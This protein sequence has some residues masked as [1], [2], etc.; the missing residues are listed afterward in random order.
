[1][2]HQIGSG[3]TRL[4]SDQ[5]MLG[6]LVVGTSLLFLGGYSAREASRVGG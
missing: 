1:M 2:Y 6:G 5:R 4:L 3:A